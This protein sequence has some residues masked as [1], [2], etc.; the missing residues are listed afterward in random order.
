MPHSVQCCSFT[1]NSNALQAAQQ[2]SSF[3]D[4][5]AQRN[6]MNAKLLSNMDREAT[7]AEQQRRRSEQ[8]LAEKDGT[9]Q[10]LQVRRRS[11]CTLATRFTVSVQ[12]IYFGRCQHL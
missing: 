3:A 1:R 10:Q 11:L 8:Q 9:I 5:M 6:E 12:S 7:K 2:A 4:A